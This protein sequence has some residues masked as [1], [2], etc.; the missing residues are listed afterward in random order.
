MVS[1]RR[2][3]QMHITLSQKEHQFLCAYSDAFELPKSYLLI[4]AFREQLGINN[5]ELYNEEEFQSLLE[6]IPCRWH[7]H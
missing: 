1:K 4:R 6:D 7:K 2:R 3:V 5:S